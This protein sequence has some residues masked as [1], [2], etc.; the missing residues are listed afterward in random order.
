LGRVQ[1]EESINAREMA[2]GTSAHA[3]H[4]RAVAL[5][6]CLQTAAYLLL[7]LAFAAA[8]LWIAGQ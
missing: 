7:A 4:G 1:G 6:G 2:A 3:R 8:V 5:A